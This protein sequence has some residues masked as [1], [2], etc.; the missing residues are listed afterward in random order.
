MLKLHLTEKDGVL[1]YGIGRLFRAVYLFFA[2]VII[3]GAGTYLSENDTSNMVLPMVFV[4][5]MLLAAGY[6]EQ[7][8]F[9]RE[10]QLVSYRIGLV[11]LSRRREF[12][13]NEIEAFELNHFKKGQ[14]EVTSKIKS[15]AN[16]LYTTYAVTLLSGEIHDIEII[17]HKKSAGRT[18]QAAVTIASYC[19]KPLSQDMEIT[20]DIEK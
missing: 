7:W 19:G 2:V 9:D 13:F 8:V 17:R 18:E 10:R 3:I 16:R 15:R 14:K 5:I 12:S 11:F 6:R 20:E 1:Y 4:V